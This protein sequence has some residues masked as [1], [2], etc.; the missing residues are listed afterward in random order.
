MEKENFYD[1][2]VDASMGFWHWLDIKFCLKL[3]NYNQEKKEKVWHQSF[4]WEA[5]LDV[6][7]NETT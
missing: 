3:C 7:I 1:S 4:V 5:G 2:I 6:T